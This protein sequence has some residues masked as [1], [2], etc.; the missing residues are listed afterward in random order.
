MTTDIPEMQDIIDVKLFCKCMEN[1]PVDVKQ[2]VY[3]HPGE[4][5]II[6]EEEYEKL[7]KQ[8]RKKC[9]L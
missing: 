5:D 8:H 3:W 7:K 4:Y 9:K 2:N 1:S 6:S